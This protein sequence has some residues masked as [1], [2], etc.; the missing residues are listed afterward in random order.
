MI[1]RLKIMHDIAKEQNFSVI[2][3]E[4]LLV[5]LE[6]TLKKLEQDLKNLIQ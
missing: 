2:K 3:K 1:E 6:T 4:E 5:D